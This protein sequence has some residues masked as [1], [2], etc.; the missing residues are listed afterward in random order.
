MTRTDTLAAACPERSRWPSSPSPSPPSRSRACGGDSVPGNAVAKVDDDTHREE[1][2][3]PLDADRRDLR[4]GAAQ[5]GDQARRSRSR[6]RRTSPS[7]SPSKKKT[8]PKPPRASPSRPT[9]QLKAQCKQEYEG[10]RDQVMQLLIQDEW[11]H[12]EA[13]QQDVKVTDAEVKKAFDEQKKQSFPKEGDYE[14]F[15]KTSGMTEEDVLFRV[16]LEQLSNKLREKVVKGKDKVSDEQIEELLRQEQDA[17]RPARAPRPAHRPDQDQGEGRRRP[18]RRSRAASRGRR[19]PRSTRSTR[20]PRTRAARCS[21]VAKG[22][23]EPALDKAVFAAQKGE[24][25]GP[26]KTQFGYYVFEV[27]KV[28]PASQQ[29]LEQAKATIK[30]HPRLPEPAEGARRSSSRTSRRSGRRRRTAARAT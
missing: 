7:A 22:Q 30:R 15:L 1:H 27:Q 19:S 16:R 10:L 3:R 2:L 11:V 21:R 18:R 29:T 28:T 17:L 14:K 26:V 9:T 23:Q 6:T 4:P 12:G 25:A 24:L 20:P 13:E 5:T 8:A